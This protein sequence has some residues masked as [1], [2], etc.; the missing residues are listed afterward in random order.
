[1]TVAGIVFI[2]RAMVSE[3][4]FTY[5]AMCV[6]PYCSVNEVDSCEECINIYDP[7]AM[8]RATP[9]ESAMLMTALNADCLRWNAEERRLEPIRISMRREGEAYYYLTESMEVAQAVQSGSEED[10]ARCG[11]FNYFATRDCAEKA[12]RR[13]R[14]TLRKMDFDN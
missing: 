3:H 4:T 8:R 11:A 5:H 9:E 7:I 12:A 13:L 10:A 14:Q 2:F 6:S 1:M